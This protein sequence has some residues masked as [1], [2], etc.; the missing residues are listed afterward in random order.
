MTIGGNIVADTESAEANRV[1]FASPS[2]LPEHFQN[3]ICNHDH[4]DGRAG[5]YALSDRDEGRINEW[6][7]KHFPET[8][9]KKIV[10]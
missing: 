6:M 4:P 9:S 1:W 2:I 7:R 8:E 5:F 10:V 3:R